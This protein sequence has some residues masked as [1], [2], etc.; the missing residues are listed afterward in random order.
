[1]ATSERG[2]GHGRSRG[3][4]NRQP[5]FGC[6]VTATFPAAVFGR[7]RADVGA[8]R[9]GG[10]LRPGPHGSPRRSQGL[11]PLF[12][13]D[14]NLMLGFSFGRQ[15][16]QF[17]VAPGLVR[18]FGSARNRPFQACRRCRKNETVR[19]RLKCP[20]IVWP[21]G[22]ARLAVCRGPD[23]HLGRPVGLARRVLLPARR[24]WPRR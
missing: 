2:D 7:C 18:T 1:L 12:D 22:S 24:Q 16:T 5:F 9:R 23:R 8:C 11:G 17:P 6:G 13:R 19:P 14:S 15:G 20:F 4:K 21:A 10:L 3:I